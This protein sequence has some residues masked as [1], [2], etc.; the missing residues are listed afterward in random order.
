MQVLGDSPRSQAR[1][2][3]TSSRSS[4]TYAR[5][6]TLLASQVPVDH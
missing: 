2:D 6:G 4:T 3:T 5:R 1:D